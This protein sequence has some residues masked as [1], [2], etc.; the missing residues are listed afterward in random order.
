MI[1]KSEDNKIYT[2]AEPQKLTNGD[3]IRMGLLTDKEMFEI[4][5]QLGRS[6]KEW[7]NWLREEADH[8]AIHD[9]DS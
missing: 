1:T 9:R 3:L 5:V 2:T 8:E 4:C 7:F 6:S